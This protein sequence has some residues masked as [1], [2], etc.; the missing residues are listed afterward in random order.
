M[1]GGKGAPLRKYPSAPPKRR[2]CETPTGPSL[3]QN[4]YGCRPYPPGFRIGLQKKLQP[5]PSELTWKCA[6]VGMGP[7]NAETTETVSRPRQ[8]KLLTPGQAPPPASSIEGASGRDCHFSK[9]V[10]TEGG[11]IVSC[12]AAPSSPSCLTPLLLS[13]FPGPLFFYIPPWRHSEVHEARRTNHKQLRSP[14]EKG[15]RQRSRRPN[16][17]EANPTPASEFQ[18]PLPLLIQTPAPRPRMMT[19]MMKL[20]IT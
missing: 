5:P 17:N 18:P 7:F 1:C 11:G 10:L 12:G 9:L 20:Q 4:G 15:W 3:R 8:K 16:P 2:L 13:F 19:C 6:I 14:H